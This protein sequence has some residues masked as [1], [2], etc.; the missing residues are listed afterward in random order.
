VLRGPGFWSWDFGL[1]RDFAVLNGRSLQFRFEAFNML[2]TPRFNNP[3][4]N[5][6]NLQ[7]NPDGS[8]RN[9]NGFSEI[10]GTSGGSE[11]LMRLGLRLG[12]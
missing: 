7:L 2:D 6:S 4:G 10:T 1:F 5:V 9:L 12:F 11:R 8:I 3:G